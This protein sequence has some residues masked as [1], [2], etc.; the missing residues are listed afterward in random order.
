M[1]DLEFDGST[2][3]AFS[4]LSGFKSML[5]GNAEQAYEALDCLYSAAYRCLD[6]RRSVAGLAVSDCVVSWATDIGSGISIQAEVMFEF[7]RE[8]HR[9]VL[10]GSYLVTTTVAWGQH[11]YQRRIELP[12][13]QKG[14]LCGSAY[15]NA[16]L[17]N[18]SAETGSIILLRNGCDWDPTTDG[19][20]A[21]MWNRTRAGWEFFWSANG[22]HEVPEII[23]ARRRIKE[24][25]F[26][27]FKRIYSGEL[28]VPMPPR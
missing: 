12:N 13:L 3:V 17:R 26:Q 9:S 15:I 18:R 27:A 21:A 1:P 4:D 8:L 19:Q 7:L 10:D 28:R 16:Y 11:R 20:M 22:P 23:S 6:N 25:K 5:R 14:A 2:F 24:M